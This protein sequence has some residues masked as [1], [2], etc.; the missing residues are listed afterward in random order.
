M[1]WPNTGTELDDHVR[2]IGTEA[3]YHLS[4]RVCHDAKLGSFASGMHKANRRRFRIHDVN[5]ATVCDVNAER[6]ATLIRN[7]AIA[8]GEFAAHSAAA[9]AVDYRNFMTVDLFGGEQRPLAHA[10]CVANFLMCSVEPLQHFGFI[11]GDVDSGN[12]LCE[13]VMTEFDRV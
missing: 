7:N 2:G 5:R 12:S 1:R 6:D 4:D 13:N 8:R 3:F 10:D 11:V 9:T